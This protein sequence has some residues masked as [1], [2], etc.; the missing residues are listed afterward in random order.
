MIPELTHAPFV[1][2]SYALF[3][4]VMAW[5]FLQPLLKRRKLIRNLEESIAERQAARRMT[6]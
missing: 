6:S 3:A 4:V 2:S 1:W 5:Q